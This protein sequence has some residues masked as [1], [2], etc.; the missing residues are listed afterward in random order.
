MAR[1]IIFACGLQES[2]FL[3]WFEI[4]YSAIV[5]K[6]IVYTNKNSCCFSIKIIQVGFFSQC[7][8]GSLLQSLLTVIWSAV[9]P[10][11]T[12]FQKYLIRQRLGEGITKRAIANELNVSKNALLV[13][14][15]IFVSVT[16][17]IFV[18]CHHTIVNRAGKDIKNDRHWLDIIK[19][20][21]FSKILLLQT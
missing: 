14:K 21:T 8:N 7:R 4:Y 10:N 11:L 6:V 9:M 17:G 3:P 5:T 1:F 20:P 18:L 19:F 15:Q 12:E 16:R 13:A 2:T